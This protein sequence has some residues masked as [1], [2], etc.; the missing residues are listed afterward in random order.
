MWIYVLVLVPY[1]HAVRH[2]LM[3]HCV[4]VTDGLQELHE[5]PAAMDSSAVSV[6]AVIPRMMTASGGCH[7]AVTAVAAPA[8]RPVAKPDQL[9]SSP[10]AR[11]KLLRSAS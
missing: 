10:T 4:G 9:I 2:H 11:P 8:Q 6:S 5:R 1:V 3:V 7:I